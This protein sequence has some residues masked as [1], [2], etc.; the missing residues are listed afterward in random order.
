MLADGSVRGVEVGGKK[1]AWKLDDGVATELTVDGRAANREDVPL[2]AVRAEPIAKLK[3][4][5][6]TFEP[7]FGEPRG[8]VRDGQ[9]VLLPAK[10]A[11]GFD[12]VS[13]GKSTRDH[14]VSAT[15]M[16]EGA[17]GGLIARGNRGESSFSGIAVLVSAEP[18]LAQL[19]AVD[20]LGG[21]QKLAEPAKL[22]P[23]SEAG[24]KA[25]L[26]VRGTRVE[27]RVAGQLLKATLDAAGA[28]GRAGL[29]A[30][31][32]GRFRVGD[33]RVR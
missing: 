11:T 21:A 3:L 2:R 27:A 31:P 10:P 9:L 26:S 24:W 22:P 5:A 32:G 4:G 17:G 29:L 8:V 28:L 16:P 19:V 25:S 7:L 30:R 13:F 12:A 14:T 6:V 20:G 15:L 1:W 23:P 18:P 33:P